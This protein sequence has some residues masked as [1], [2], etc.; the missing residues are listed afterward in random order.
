M[1]PSSI[2]DVTID[3][4]TSPG[5]RDPR[6]A[7]V[8]LNPASRRALT[9]AA[10]EAA[11]SPLAARGWTV[12]VEETASAAE[13]R[14]RA[15]THARRGTH[16]IL[17]CGGDGALLAV[18]NGVRDAGPGTSAVGSAVGAVPAGTGDAWARE[19]R[20]P[21]DL[22][23]ALALLEDGARRRVDLGVARIG[24]GGTPVR[25][26]LVCGVGIDAAIVGA[27]ERQPRAKRRL[28]RLVYALPALV[29]GLAWPA[30]AMRVE[31]D[32][33][34]EDRTGVLAALIANTR[35]YG[36]VAHLT[37][38]ARVDDGLL[39]VVTLAPRGLGERAALALAGLLGSLEGGRAAGVAYGRARRIV[40]T[41][42]RAL[43]VQAD[44]EPIGTCG[45]GAPLIVEVEPAAVTMIV[46]PGANPLWDSERDPEWDSERGGEPAGDRP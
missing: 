6:S 1:A 12:T 37:A 46:G 30:S 7:V 8:L 43:P 39:D 35:R 17:A 42:S 44:G 41:P 32:G 28:G 3:P 10:V 11:A 2:A 45:P 40:L 33:A 4:S 25:F 15:A 5:A 36:G 34:S 19:A 23:G 29:A 22:E 14:A 9:R 16:A 13:M 38:S 26:L 27:V 24:A 31:L 18:L 21:R 20:I